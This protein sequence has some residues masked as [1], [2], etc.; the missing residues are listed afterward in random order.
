M[1]K[2]L[3]V[4]P[5]NKENKLRLM[6]LENIARARRIKHYIAYS[7]IGDTIL[8]KWTSRALIGVSRLYIKAKY[9]TYLILADIYQ[10]GWKYAFQTTLIFAAFYTYSN[11][12]DHFDSVFHDQYA[13]VQA[14]WNNSTGGG[15]F[16]LKKVAFETNNDIDKFMATFNEVEVQAYIKRFSKVAMVEM[17]KY[18]VPASI[19]VALSIMETQSDKNALA[20]ET[21]NHFG[22]P[23]A[24][25]IYHS[26]WENW[27]AHTLM[28]KDKYPALFELTPNSQQWATT[29]QKLGYSND[30]NYARKIL[31]IIDRFELDYLNEV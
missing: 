4:Y 2:D 1:M 20:N 13:I 29:L 26:A 28:L 15:K 30:P 19:K 9:G 12:K 16:H 7:P 3:V 27:R 25:A 31:E 11:E 5:V 22:L 6:R 18:G 8:G 10:K 23:M 21:N 14:A 17:E 24:G